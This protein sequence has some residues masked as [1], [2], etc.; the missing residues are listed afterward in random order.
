MQQSLRGWGE[1]E[2]EEEGGLV[3]FTELTGVHPRRAQTGQPTVTQKDKLQLCGIPSPNIC[4]CTT[5][6]NLPALST[7]TLEICA[8][9][10]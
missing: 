3:R 8:V 9:F 2:E 6:P 5:F 10:I 4:A 7:Q 1:E